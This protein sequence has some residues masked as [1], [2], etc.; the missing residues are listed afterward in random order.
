MGKARLRRWS[1]SSRDSECAKL[2]LDNLMEDGCNLFLK[3]LVGEEL[4]MGLLLRT[5]REDCEGF[6]L[7]WK[8]QLPV[9]KFR[10]E[11]KVIAFSHMISVKRLVEKGTCRLPNI[12]RDGG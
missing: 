6:F 3:N 2:R 5:T 8:F 7:F 12:A 1:E 11:M 4:K 9:E 10:L